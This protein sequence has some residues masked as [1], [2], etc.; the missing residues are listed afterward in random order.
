MTTLNRAVSG[1]IGGG[2]GGDSESMVKVNTGKNISWLLVEEDCIAELH[3][4]DMLLCRTYPPPSSSLLCVY[5]VKAL[6]G[7]IC[8]IFN[9]TGA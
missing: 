5:D 2:R 9:V 1:S 8:S 3:R 6:T 4:N 7:I